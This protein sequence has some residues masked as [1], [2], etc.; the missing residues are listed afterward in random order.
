MAGDHAKGLETIKP[1]KDDYSFYSHTYWDAPEGYYAR[2]TNEDEDY[3]ITEEIL[4]ENE[5]WSFVTIVENELQSFSLPENRL[6]THQ[7]SITKYGDAHFKA[8]CKHTGESFYTADFNIAELIKT[9]DY[10]EQ[11]KCQ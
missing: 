3:S 6:D 5:E 9:N 11:R 8:Y 2:L 7:L 1:F 4:G 10:A